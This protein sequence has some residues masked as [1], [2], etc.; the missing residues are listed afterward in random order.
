M[1][2]RKELKIG[3]FA[4]TVI[5][6]SFFMLNFFKGKDILNKNIELYSLVEDIDGL[7]VSSQVL[8]KGFVIG[9]VGDIEYL[10]DSKNFKITY[11]IKK[12]FKLPVDTKF[13]I[14]GLE[15]MGTKGV[16]V[17][18][19]TSSK[20]VESEEY[21]Q[22][23]VVPNMLDEL[24]DNISPILLGLS[25]TLGRVDSIAIN[26]NSLFSEQNKANISSAISN[27]NFTVKEVKELASSINGRSN[28]IQE[29]ISNL[30]DLAS[31]LVVIGEKADTS[32]DNINDI[33][34]SINKA[35]VEELLKS[36]NGLLD[37]IQD[38]DGS[39]GKLLNEDAIYDSADKLIL[40]INSLITEI[41]NNPKKYIKITIF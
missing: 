24:T 10:T 18:M 14:L 36:F 19:G 22:S 4:V 32:I 5:L 20:M 40:D 3:I 16:K 30:E 2:K 7:V 26:I 34:E 37:K 8:M 25:Q 35:N 31:K 9:K 41:K 15:V 17:K 13:T 23:V 21:I 38:P 39:I 33:S 28:D 1:Y 12:E 27:L 11:I 6:V 29:F